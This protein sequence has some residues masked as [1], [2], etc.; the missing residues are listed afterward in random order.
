[1]GLGE[2]GRGVAALAATCLATVATALALHAG[3]GTAP[4]S[5][6]TVEQNDSSARAAR[7]AN[8]LPLITTRT[9]DFTTDEG[10]WISLDLAPDAETIV[11]ELLGDLYTLPIGGG[12][13]TRITSGQGYDMQP[14]YSTDGTEIVFVSDRDGSENIWVAN[15]DGSDPRQLTDTER[16][17]YMSPV[18]TPEGEYVMANKGTQLWLYHEDGGTGVQITGQGAEAGPGG[19]PGAGQGAPSHIGAAFGPDPR[20]VWLNVR[21][22]L[23]GGFPVGGGDRYNLDPDPPDHYATAESSAREVGAFPDRDARP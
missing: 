7:R 20:Y 5:A 22:N 17:N 10:T 19:G 16:E 6:Q 18:W 3:P 12:T 13:A 8:S 15:A 1:M 2:G 9:L 21:G 4:L 14:R 23:G 11:F